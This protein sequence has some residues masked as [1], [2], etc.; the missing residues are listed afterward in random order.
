MAKFF[1]KIG[2][3]IT[4][5]TRPG[6]WTET[7]TEREYRGDII[8]NIRRLQAPN[9]TLNDNLSITNEFSIVAD[10]YAYRNFHAMRWIEWMGSKWKIASVDVQRPR[11]NLT[12][13]GLYN[14]S[15]T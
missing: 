11:L 12:I 2:Y 1:G 15:E 5:E 4:E 7:I 6:V 8:R 9:E 3:A 13:G 14:G 10:A